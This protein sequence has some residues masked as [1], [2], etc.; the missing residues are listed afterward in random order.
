[1]TLS[2][3]ISLRIVC[4]LFIFFS[5][6]YNG[7][8]VKPTKYFSISFDKWLEQRIFRIPQDR[9]FNSCNDVIFWTERERE[10]ELR[11][12]AY[13]ND[14]FKEENPDMI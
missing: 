1:M 4:F 14:F 9:C 10:R 5:K 13:F 11:L 3:E 6:A 12:S 2:I 8:T 7:L